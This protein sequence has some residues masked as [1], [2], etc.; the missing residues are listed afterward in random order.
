MRYADVAVLVADI[1]RR[2]GI[3]CDNP[4]KLYL[5]HDTLPSLIGEIK[6]YYEESKLELEIEVRSTDCEDGEL[7]GLFRRYR[8][9]RD[10]VIISVNNT[11][12]T[13]WSRFVE[14]KELAHILI[15]RDESSFTNDLDRLIGDLL[16][17]DFDRD[18]AK[19]V[20]MERLAFQFAVDFL[21]PPCFDEYVSD[22]SRS[23]YEVAETFMVPERIIDLI[24]N[25]KYL[26]FRKDAY[27]DN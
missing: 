1:H 14:A 27:R 2:M 21:V 8:N 7:Y 13:C 26:Q 16:S 12:N 19:D 23:S 24:R 20:E 3:D 5:Y 4:A 22:L 18:I 25:D 6:R 17:G 15:G 10:R 9:G 11:L